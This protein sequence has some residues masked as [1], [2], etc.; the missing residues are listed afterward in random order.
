MAVVTCMVLKSY[1]TRMVIFERYVLVV[2]AYFIQVD[3]FKTNRIVFDI[4]YTHASSYEIS[5]ELHRTSQVSQY[6]FTGLDVSC[7]QS[8]FKAMLSVWTT[9]F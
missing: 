7:N 8:L 1:G 4:K 9:F 5:I 2:Y 6:Y 3:G